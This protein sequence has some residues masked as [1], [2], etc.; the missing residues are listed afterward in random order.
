MLLGVIEAGES[1]RGTNDKKQF[2]PMT[3]PHY[4]R[5]YEPP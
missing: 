5:K 2:Q 1:P 4:A 3:L